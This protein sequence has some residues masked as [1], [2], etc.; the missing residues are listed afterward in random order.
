M[1]DCDKK[2]GGGNPD[3]LVSIASF[4]SQPLAIMGRT[5]AQ[6]GIAGSENIQEVTKG[7]HLRNAPVHRRCIRLGQDLLSVH[8]NLA[9]WTMPLP[10]MRSALLVP[11][12][13]CKTIPFPNYYRVV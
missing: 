13:Q 2:S 6:D 4:C 8:G 9:F 1:L 12:Q 3:D 7:T 11:L 5:S 10:S